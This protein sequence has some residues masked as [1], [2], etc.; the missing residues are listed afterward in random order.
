[1]IHDFFI[2]EDVIVGEFFPILQLAVKLKENDCIAVPVVDSRD[3]AVPRRSSQSSFSPRGLS[4]IF[5]RSS[6][7]TV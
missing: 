6:R 4:R 1:M 7:F 5:I 3:F 2:F